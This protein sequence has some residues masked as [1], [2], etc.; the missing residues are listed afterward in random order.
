M[1]VAEHN[2]T[3]RITYETGDDGM[4]QYQ[5]FGEVTYTGFDLALDLKPH[6]AVNVKGSYTYLEAKDEETGL[7]IPAKADNQGTLDVYLKPFDHLSLSVKTKAVSRVYRNKANTKTVPGYA[8]TDVYGEY[9][10][11]RFSLFTEIENVFDKTY[12]YSDGLLGPGLTWKIGGELK[13]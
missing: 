8:T 5:N 13:I 6:R 12:F 9:S 2:L 10:F 3:D 1:S 4:G 11:G 7:A